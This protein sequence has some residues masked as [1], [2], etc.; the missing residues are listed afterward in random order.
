[1]KPDIIIVGLHATVCIHKLGWIDDVSLLD[2]TRQ[3][4]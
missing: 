4:Y 1:M 3:F 2:L